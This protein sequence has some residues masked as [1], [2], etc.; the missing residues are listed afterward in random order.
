M[1]R[2][3]IFPP[4]PRT[5]KGASPPG[6]H[7]DG[8]V[9]YLYSTVSNKEEAQRRAENYRGSFPQFSVRVV[10]VPRGYG[11]YYSF[12]SPLHPTKRRG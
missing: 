6:K 10:K 11:V 3:S 7:I 2:K 9:Y 12:P 8:R 1:V 4:M 5:K